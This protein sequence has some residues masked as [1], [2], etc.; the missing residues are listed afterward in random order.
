M[1][2]P[3]RRLSAHPSVET[4]P[5]TKCRP[6]LKRC[7]SLES[8]E[9]EVPRKRRRI[10]I[11]GVSSGSPKDVSSA[12]QSKSD[13]FPQTAPSKID[14]AL[15]T[16]HP[17]V[18]SARAGAEY[19]ERMFVC[20]A[21]REAVCT[22]LK[23]RDDVAAADASVDLKM[24]AQVSACYLVQVFFLSSSLTIEDHGATAIA[25]A[26]AAVK[27]IG[28]QC[29]D[30]DVMK[31]WSSR[32]AAVQETKLATASDA[33]IVTQISLLEQRLLLESRLLQLCHLDEPLECLA[34]HMRKSL[35]ESKA[36]GEHALNMS[37]TE[38]KQKAQR[39]ILDGFQGS[40]SLSLSPQAMVGGALVMASKLI[41]GRSSVGFTSEDE[42]VSLLC[43]NSTYVLT[44]SEIK[45]AVSEIAKVYRAWKSQAEQS[46]ALLK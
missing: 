2:G 19:V 37:D 42:L 21:A 6:K 26:S 35:F 29:N 20:V 41:C 31:L 34:A 24:R 8:A 30:E 10:I 1:V 38:L 18:I 44:H 14:Y 9:V 23:N 16:G 33:E 28:M 43:A 12:S 46:T 5:P 40:G 45:S 39:L 27:E 13:D 25:A 7:D 3:L 17:V 32:H 11:K 36:A 22:F 4:L 15:S